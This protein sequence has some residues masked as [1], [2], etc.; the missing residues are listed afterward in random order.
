M[1][2]SVDHFA[3][4]NKPFQGS[5]LQLSPRQVTLMSLASQSNY[6]PVKMARLCRVSL[7]QLERLF[8]VESGYTPRQWL[9]MQRLNRALLLLPKAQSVKQVAYLLAYAQ[10]PQFCREFKA[11]F[12][13]TPEQFRKSQAC[14]RDKMLT[15]NFG[16]QKDIGPS[17]PLQRILDSET[18][19]ATP[20][21]RTSSAC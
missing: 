20:R 17:H 2:D 14:T 7:R 18:I 8:K 1:N 6:Q 19:V 16:R 3:E 10:I 5:V 4:D 9:R 12:G 21:V 11:R 13:I 15:A